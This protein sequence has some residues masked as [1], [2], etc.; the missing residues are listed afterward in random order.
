[1]ASAF[2]WEAW[3][4]FSNDFLRS[5]TA[6]RLCIFR[7]IHTQRWS[8]YYYGKDGLNS[9]SQ[10]RAVLAA[11]LFMPSTELTLGGF[12]AKQTLRHRGNS[13]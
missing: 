4:G 10:Q 11:K 9:V 5:G 6:M 8:L 3:A 13:R 2:A 12:G 1:M 7:F